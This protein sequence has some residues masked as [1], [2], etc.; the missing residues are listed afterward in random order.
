MDFPDEF[1]AR[2][3]AAGLRP[4]DHVLVNAHNLT[5]FRSGPENKKNGFYRLTVL[6][7]HNGD[8]L[9]FGMFGCWKRNIEVKWSSKDPAKY[10]PLDRARQTQ[11]QD[12]LRK[13]NE[14]KKH[15]AAVRAQKIWQRCASGAVDPSHPYLVKKQIEPR[16]I[17]QMKHQL[18]IPVF[19]D[20]HLVSLQFIAADGSKL[21]LT[22]GRTQ[23]GYASV[24]DKNDSREIIIIA[25][26]YATAASIYQAMRMPVVVAFNAGNL[27]PVAQAIRAKYPNAQIIIAADNDQW[28]KGNP[29][30]THATAAANAVDARVVFPAFH[31]GDPR[32]P[33]DFN[34]L[35]LAAGLQAIRDTFAGTPPDL[36]PPS[37]GA[38]PARVDAATPE[39]PDWRA[40][41]L[42]GKQ[43]VNGYPHPFDGKSKMNA[44][45]FVKHH[46][47]FRGLFVYNEFTDEVMV[48]RCPQWDDPASFR[49]R[50][51]ADEDYFMIAAH[52]EYCDMRVSKE[53]AAEATIK[54]AKENAVN[55]PRDYFERL[56]WDGVKRLDAWL[57]YYLGAD[58]QPPE[59]L[60]LV[61]SKWLIGAVSRIY[62]PGCKFDSVLILEGVQGLGKSVALRTLATFGGEEFFCDSVGDIRN[63]DT[64][65]TLQGKV[66]VEMA[67]LASFKKNEN[68]EIKAFITR[69]VDEYRP[70]YGRGVQKRPRY[71]V[72]AGSTNEI[73]EGYLTDDTG[74]RRYWPVKCKAADVA[75]LAE[76]R[77]QLWA[78]AAQRYK[79]G[80]RT[81]LDPGELR[82]S[83]HEQ[84][85]RLMEDAW[86]EQ[87]RMVL[88]GEWETD[89]EKICK[90]LELK[91][92]DINNLTK[93]RI[94]KS[95]HA[96]G[97]FET[98]RAGEGRIWKPEANKGVARPDLLTIEM[99][100]D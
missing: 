90:K 91:P 51:L 40:K 87:I 74:N 70:P 44:Y 53:T 78:E 7:G 55:P 6:K 46:A 5:R 83:T 2:I 58:E 65:M 45:C 97:W 67:E 17:R 28:T 25:E 60:A 27:K 19:A 69:Q 80:E 30:I 18:V 8:D 49:P 37:S 24:S 98:K 63:K 86:Q 64:I 75:A 76:A 99:P 47:L 81:Y 84:K 59:Y 94:K 21:F 29:G 73:D 38:L 62:Q 57:T 10:T 61:G 33:T 26:G 13:V 41:L 12:R 1:S 36:T 77:E 85:T 79:A 15:N 89:V 48:I 71:F 35:H 14:E 88:I 93:R 50:R 11:E 39:P 43:V 54:V 20:G 82:F 22:G 42:S 56:R 32:K 72:L 96:L 3:A 66:I 92:R 34:D 100:F 4:P 68:E 52:L 9:A 23:G 95:L 31:V 16:G